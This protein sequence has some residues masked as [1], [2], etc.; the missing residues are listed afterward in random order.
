LDDH[1]SVNDEG[2]RHESKAKF[3]VRVHDTHVTR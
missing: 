1:C 2:E 3:F